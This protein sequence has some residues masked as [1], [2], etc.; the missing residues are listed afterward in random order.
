MKNTKRVSVR[1]LTM[2]L[3]MLMVGTFNFVSAQG[4]GQGQGYGKK[5][6]KYGKMGKKGRKMRKGGNGFHF[7]PRMI[8][9]LKITDDQLVKIDAIRLEFQKKRIDTK[10]S[11]DKIK[12]EKREAI[13][14]EDFSNAKKITEQYFENRKVEE[15]NKLDMMEKMLNQLTP[16]QRKKFKTLKRSRTGHHHGYKGKMDGSNRGPGRMNK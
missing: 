16:E 10:A 9:E 2:A 8:E 6:A 13:K 12:L 14:N 3:V 4:M 11:M 7:G 5:Q 15:I 1:F